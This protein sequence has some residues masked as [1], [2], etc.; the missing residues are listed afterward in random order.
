MLA[1]NETPQQTVNVCAIRFAL[2]DWGMQALVG[3]E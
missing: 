3:V 2:C 1:T